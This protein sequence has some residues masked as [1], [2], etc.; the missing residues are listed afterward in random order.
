MRGITKKTALLMMII[1]G[2]IG[3]YASHIDNDILNDILMIAENVAD[4][5]V[6]TENVETCVRNGCWEYLAVLEDEYSY[7][8]KCCDQAKVELRGILDRRFAEQLEHE[9]QQANMMMAQVLGHFGQPINFLDQLGMEFEVYQDDLDKPKEVDNPGLQRILDQPINL[10]KDYVTKENINNY[11]DDIGFTWPED[12]NNVL[13]WPDGKDMPDTMICTEAKFGEDR[14]VK[15]DCFHP[16]SA[17]KA[18]GDRN[19]NPFTG[20]IKKEFSK[21][22]YIKEDSVMDEIPEKKQSE[23]SVDE[24]SEDDA[25][26]GEP[27]MEEQFLNE[28]FE[29]EKEHIGPY[30]KILNSVVDDDILF[31]KIDEI[32]YNLYKDELNVLKVKDLGTIEEIYNYKGEVVTN[33]FKELYVHVEQN[34]DFQLAFEK[35]EDTEE[36]DDYEWLFGPPKK[37]GNE[38]KETTKETVEMKRLFYFSKSKRKYRQLHFDTP[39]KEEVKYPVSVLKTKETHEIYGGRTYYFENTEKTF[40]KLFAIKSEYKI[41]VGDNPNDLKMKEFDVWK[42]EQS[43]DDIYDRQTRRR[44]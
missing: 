23:D 34:D 20:E 25:S 42:N 38:T 31:R 2:V 36:S 17:L 43:D 16:Q 3:C 1:I 32:Y 14:K 37:G 41:F 39:G 24:D 4:G 35:T 40:Q 28:N 12:K 10:I 22:M 9:E 33:T 19:Q 21:M 18:I 27:D 7:L 11:M 15:Y 13:I 5:C 26:N 30:T 8:D 44:Y 6:A 29:K